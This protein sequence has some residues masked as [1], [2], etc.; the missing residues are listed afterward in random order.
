MYG[1]D[2]RTRCRCAPQAGAGN[3]AAQGPTG[4]TASKSPP[5]SNHSHSPSVSVCLVI[6]FFHIDIRRF[7]RSDQGENIIVTVA[8]RHPT[9]CKSPLAG[10]LN[11]IIVCLTVFG[12]WLSGVKVGLLECSVKKPYIFPFVAAP[13]CVCHADLLLPHVYTI[14]HESIHPSIFY[15]SVPLRVVGGA[16]AYASIYT[17]IND[18]NIPLENNLKHVSR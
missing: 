6:H 17:I 15:R 14:I 1:Q 2:K 7:K 18:S 9:S 10:L 5:T 4:S 3:A 13:V 8:L 16:G 12:H 11:D